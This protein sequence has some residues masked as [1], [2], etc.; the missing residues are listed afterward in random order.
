MQYGGHTIVYGLSHVG[1]ASGLPSYFVQMSTAKFLVGIW[2]R[3][4]LQLKYNILGISIHWC[5]LYCVTI[6][7]FMFASR[8]SEEKT[9]PAEAKNLPKK[10]A[11]L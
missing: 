4:T 3:R 9:D 10:E 2:L 8:V 11:L 7:I 6:R 5:T 1:L